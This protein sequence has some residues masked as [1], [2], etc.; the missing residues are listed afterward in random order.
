ML[1]NHRMQGAQ[2]PE[3]RGVRMCTPQE[4]GM[5]GTPQMAIFQHFKVEIKKWMFCW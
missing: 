3:D 5:S 4:Q 2:H 1:K